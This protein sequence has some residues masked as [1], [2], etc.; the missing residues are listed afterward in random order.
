MQALSMSNQ[1]QKLFL[2]QG[3]LMRKYHSQRMS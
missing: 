1:C 2:I 3:N